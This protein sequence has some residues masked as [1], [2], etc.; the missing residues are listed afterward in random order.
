[1]IV[2]HSASTW[3][4]IRSGCHKSSVLTAGRL[5]MALKREGTAFHLDRWK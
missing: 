3:S 5:S 1:L 4:Y 2:A